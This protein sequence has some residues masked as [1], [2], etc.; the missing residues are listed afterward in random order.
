MDYENAVHRPHNHRCPWVEHQAHADLPRGRNTL[1]AATP[2]LPFLERRRNH[3]KWT[4]LGIW[5]FYL[6][7]WEAGRRVEIDLTNSLTFLWAIPTEIARV[8]SEHN[9]LV[10]L[11]VEKFFLSWITLY[12][13]T[14]NSHKECLF[15]TSFLLTES[16]SV[17]HEK[18][19][20]ALAF[21]SGFLSLKACQ[22]SFNVILFCQRKF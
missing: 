7:R 5:N 19:K 21:Q 22:K 8:D 17:S 1:P 15:S 13:S 2:D 11:E 6:G 12:V 14:T 20:I 3:S 10:C 9:Y 4:F 16:L 18:K